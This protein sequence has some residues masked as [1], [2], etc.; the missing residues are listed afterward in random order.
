VRLLGDV[1]HPPVVELFQVP[2][3]LNDLGLKARPLVLEAGLRPIGALV[4]EPLL[5][6]LFELDRSCKAAECRPSGGLLFVRAMAVDDTAL[7]CALA[8]HQVL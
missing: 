7:V 4:L 5:E 3:L 2:L 8:L 1:I 6:G